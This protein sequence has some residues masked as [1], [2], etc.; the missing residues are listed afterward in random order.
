MEVFDAGRRGSEEQ[1][2][3]DLLLEARGLAKVE[4]I[5]D[6]NEEEFAELGGS[7]L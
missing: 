2:Q 1:E 3:G 7:D 6:E 5:S 4:R